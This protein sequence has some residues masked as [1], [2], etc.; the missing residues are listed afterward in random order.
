MAK[1]TFYFS[2]DYNARNDVKIKKL[3][4]KHG[5]L[6]YGIF[7]ALIEELYNNTNV[8]PLDYDSISFDL[9]ID[10]LILQSIINDFDLFQIDENSFGSLSVQNRLEERNLKSKKARE[11]IAKRWNNTNVLQPNNKGNTIKERKGK[12]NKGKESKTKE[13][14]ELIFPFDSEAFKLAWN[15]LQKEKK[16]VKKSHAAL[17]ASLNKLSKHNEQQAIL[18]IEAA[19]AGEW[20]GIHEINNQIPFTSE[21]VQKNVS[22]PILANQA[23]ENAKKRL[24]END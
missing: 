11:S 18:M 7:W 1:D 13:A 20:Q 23:F 15:V 21:N 22:K 10:K 24:F 14:F 4:F 3:L 16:W 6:G 17:Q 19:I 8:L 9:R 12:E 2:H 5:L